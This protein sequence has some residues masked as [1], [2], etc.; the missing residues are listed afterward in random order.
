MPEE[1]E[2]PRPPHPSHAQGGTR[3]G[4]GG[5]TALSGVAL[6]T[7][8]SSGI[9]RHLVE[10]L[11]ARGMAVAGLAPEDAVAIGD[12][13]SD[14]EMAPTVSRLWITAN[15]AAVDGMVGLLA[16]VPNVDVTDAAMGEGWAQAVRASL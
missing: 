5:A 11:A 9:G 13:V 16:A 1:A 6:V 7:G 2:G 15:G 4:A 12:S 8:A 3:D 14:L 10:G